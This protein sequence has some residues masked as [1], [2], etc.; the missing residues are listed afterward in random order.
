MAKENL[1][2]KANQAIWNSSSSKTTSNIFHPRN[3]FIFRTLPHPVFERK[4]ENLYT[5]MTIS[6]LD[7]LTTFSYEIDIFDKKL[8]VERE[9]PTIDGFKI[10]YKKYG[11]P[12]TNRENEEDFG[13]LIITI[14]V[15]LPRFI[16]NEA[17][18]KQLKELLL[19][20]NYKPKAYNGL[21]YKSKKLDRNGPYTGKIEVHQVHEFEK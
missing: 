11:L 2:Q 9:K 6:L 21:H 19:D 14:Q 3:N 12:F 20:E 13:F 8:K 5:N 16:F 17:E 4:G 1:F 15:E 10:L 7:S 18:K